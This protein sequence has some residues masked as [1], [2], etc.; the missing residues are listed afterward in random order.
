MERGLPGA[1][2]VV[3]ALVGGLFFTV[4]AV[5]AASGGNGRTEPGV[6]AGLIVFFGGM[7]AAGS[8]LAWRM[9]RPR[10]SA[11]GAARPGSST[12][13]GRTPR[14][15]ATS[16]ADRERRVLRLAEKERG[17]VTV[18][19]VAARCD[20]TVEEAKALLDRLVVHDVAEIHVT[21]SGVLVYVF[22]GFLS[23]RDKAR[24]R[25]F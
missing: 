10:S 3:I 8:F 18:P 4:F 23:D 12:G 13:T 9:L 7:T 20:M 15:A 16:E 25:D 6:Y 14:P 11:G 21:D 2:G 24:A 22:P 17:R 5:E 1:L 19:E